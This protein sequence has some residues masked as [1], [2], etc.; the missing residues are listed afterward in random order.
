MFDHFP[1]KV[2]RIHFRS[3]WWRF[4]T[5]L[6]R[7]LPIFWHILCSKV[8]GVPDQLF[9]TADKRWRCVY[10]PCGQLWSKGLSVHMC[11]GQ[12]IK[13]GG[14]KTTSNRWKWVKP[15]HFLINTRWMIAH[16]MTYVGVLSLIF[17]IKPIFYQKLS[18]NEIFSF[19]KDQKILKAC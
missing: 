9:L 19:S 4:L 2:N 5:I 12:L 15:W 18:K 14:D 11:S 3:I 7:N 17:S 13:G 8:I 10:R 6:Q 16:Y 1:F